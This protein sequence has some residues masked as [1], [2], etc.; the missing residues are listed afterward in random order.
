MIF[1]VRVS[2]AY[3]FSH[4][5][6]PRRNGT[7]AVSYRSDSE[8]ET[9]LEANFKKHAVSNRIAVSE[10]AYRRVLVQLCLK[11]FISRLCV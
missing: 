6:S 7:R 4:F 8:T 5:F 9:R 10:T 11:Q 2:R 1:T 3:I